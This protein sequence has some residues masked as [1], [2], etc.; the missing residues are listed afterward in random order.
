M[1]ALERVAVFLLATCTSSE[2]V[3]AELAPFALLLALRTAHPTPAATGSMRPHTYGHSMRQCI[4]PH[5]A[6]GPVRSYD[7]PIVSVVQKEAGALH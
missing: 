5:P 7:E 6:S 3:P 4:F 1:L 2:Q